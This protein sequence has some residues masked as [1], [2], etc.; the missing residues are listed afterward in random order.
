MGRKT[1]IAGIAAVLLAATL[2][3]GALV[4]DHSQEGK[5]ADGV[6]I[7]GVDVGGMDAPKRRSAGRCFDRSTGRSAP[8]TA[9]A[10]GHCPRRS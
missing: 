4:Y 2:V 9:S 10:P 5:I 6:T 1:V 8:S 7:E 3:V